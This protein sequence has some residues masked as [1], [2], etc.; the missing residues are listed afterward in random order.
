MTNAI[1]KFSGLFIAALLVTSLGFARDANDRIIEKSREAV[2]QAGPHDWEILAESAEKCIQ[3]NINVDE[4]L[5]WLDKSIEINPNKYN[6]TLKGDYYLNKKFPD[7]AIIYYLKAAE[8]TTADSH[9]VSVADTQEKI[10][11]A[12]EL[13]KQGF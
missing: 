2:D 10:K 1:K 11:K 3:K 13:K 9:K 12:L 8:I 6:L 4:A 7:E 5:E